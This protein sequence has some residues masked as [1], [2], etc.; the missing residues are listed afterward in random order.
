MC[1]KIVKAIKHPDR[2]I[3][4]IIVR[5]KQLRIAKVVKDGE[6]F[7]KYKG[8]LYSDYVSHGNACQF[9]AEKALTYCKGK[10][11]DVGAD[12]WPLRGAI[13]IQGEPHRN[14]YNLNAF[15]DN[16]L[17]YVFSSHCLEHLDRW[18]EA[19]LLWI[20]KLK[21]GG[22]LFLYLPHE[23]MKLW[24]PGEPWVGHGHKWKPQYEILLPFLS[25]HGMDIIEYNPYRDKCWSFHVVAKRISA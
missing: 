25:K 17:D 9:I 13:P 24:N 8:T 16:S 3:P 19:L 7:Y 1:N 15:A 18:Q 20:S 10:G 21:M 2:I 4:Y 11:I 14:A 6:L 23:S 22:I 5:I 12:K